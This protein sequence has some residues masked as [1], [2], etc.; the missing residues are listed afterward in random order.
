[1]QS[2]KPHSFVTFCLFWVFTACTYAQQISEQELINLREN[3]LN[4]A[5]S[6]EHRVALLD[7]VSH[8]SFDVTSFKLLS[9]SVKIFR[10]KVTNL[11]SFS[12]VERHY[13][14]DEY[15]QAYF[16]Y[17]LY[18]LW[19]SRLPM[20]QTLSEI[21]TI[22]QWAE[23][24]RIS[25]LAN[26]S[27]YTKYEVLFE[28][29]QYS[30]AIFE[31]QNHYPL[32]ISE[33]AE[34]YHF[35]FYSD[36]VAYNLG[37]TYL[38]SGNF[39]KAREYCNLAIDTAPANVSS[40]TV[41]ATLCEGIAQ[42]KLGQH[43][44]G[45]DT[46]LQAIQL[47]TDIDYKY[48]LHLAYAQ[49]AELYIRQIE[50]IEKGLEFNSLA[51]QFISDYEDKNIQQFNV[52]E[53]FAWGYLNTNPDK[54]YNFIQSLQVIIETL[55]PLTDYQNALLE[56]EANYYFNTGDVHVAYSK[57][58]LLLQNLKQQA[59]TSNVDDVEILQ[60]FLEKRHNKVTSASSKGESYPL[61]I[62]S[63]KLPHL[64][65]LLGLV[66]ITILLTA[67]NINLRIQNR[68]AN[69][70]DALTG[71]YN[72]EELIKRCNN[73][74]AK[75]PDGLSLLLVRLPNMAKINTQVGLNTA[76]ALLK[77]MGQLINHHQNI[78][79]AGRVS[80]AS[81]AL[82]VKG[83]ET[84][85]NDS[86]PVKQLIDA[87]QSKLDALEVEPSDKLLTAHIANINAQNLEHMLVKAEYDSDHHWLTEPVQLWKS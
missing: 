66:V 61:D 52:L 46:L 14:I 65:I 2:F 31:L 1:M 58:S 26:L 20:E 36:E 71:L 83:P 34:A 33:P 59:I 56:I 11:P 85:S 9:N 4:N 86:Q 17:R 78:L 12:D 53:N 37:K 16:E 57:L 87:L 44:A 41:N 13:L 23:T 3:I 42:I 35:D 60:Y 39:E 30:L 28:N 8:D 54:T 70:K 50:N 51:A 43:K 29:G 73:S 7:E 67:M 55:P 62:S 21:D 19:L 68:I 47:A 63:A 38:L 80:G 32:L 76:D 24:H 6:K 69:S 18:E 15:P 22:Y 79:L 5:Y 27:V 10:E 81:F 82:L 45:E 72:R 25:S 75:N 64:S 49:L 77:E 84:Q 48:G 40:Y 74:L